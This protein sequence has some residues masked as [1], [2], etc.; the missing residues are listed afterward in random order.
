MILIEIISDL[1]VFAFRKLCLQD[2]YLGT[3]AA[4]FLMAI[5]SQNAILKIERLKNHVFSEIFNS[6]NPKKPWEKWKIAGILYTVQ[7]G[8]QNI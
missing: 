8:G 1:D 3:V 6:Q 7:V 2:Q 4:F 5:F